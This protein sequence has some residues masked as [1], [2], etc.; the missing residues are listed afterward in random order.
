MALPSKQTLKDELVGLLQ[1][2]LD[3]L[4]RAYEASREGATHEEAK[5]ENDKDTRALEQS[6]LARGQ[7]RRVEDLRSNVADVKNMPARDFGAEE[8]VALG[9]VVCVEQN[10][11]P[12]TLFLAPQGGGAALHGGAIHVVTPR[13]PM[14]RALM[15]KLSGDD[16]EVQVAGRV[17]DVLVMEVR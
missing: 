17:L 6:Y 1:A 5:P 10:D 15:G 16:M 13:S 12:R 14:G 4:E 8:P 7:A 2:D 11:E 9:A 3:S